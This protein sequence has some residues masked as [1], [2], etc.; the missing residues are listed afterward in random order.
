[1]VLDV[2]LLVFGVH[3]RTPNMVQFSRREIFT[4]RTTN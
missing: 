2:V 1:M 3:T 4:N